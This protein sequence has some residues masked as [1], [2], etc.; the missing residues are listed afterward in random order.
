MRGSAFFREFD[1]IALI[2]RRMRPLAEIRVQDPFDTRAFDTS[3]LEEADTGRVLL[4]LPS[5]KYSEP[6]GTWD[7]DW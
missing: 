7:E 6:S 4:S 2:Q 3:D 5:Q 1:W